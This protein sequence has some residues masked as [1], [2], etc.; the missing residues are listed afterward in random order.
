MYS[1]IK[2]EGASVSGSFV[3]AHPSELEVHGSTLRIYRMYVL[4]NVSF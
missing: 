4:C 1:R 2:I 3:I